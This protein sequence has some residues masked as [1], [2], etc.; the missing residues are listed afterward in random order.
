MYR[1]V[2]NRERWFRIVLGEKYKVDARTTEKLAERVPSSFRRIMVVNQLS[3]CG[4][5]RS[6]K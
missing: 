6:I 3:H 2:M 1:G 5:K 4:Q